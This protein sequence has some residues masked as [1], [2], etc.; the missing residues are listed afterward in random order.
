MTVSAA[1]ACLPSGH[2]VSSLLLF[3]F[4]LFLSS[5][6]S[7]FIASIASSLHIAPA[8]LGSHL[9]RSTHEH[10][11]TTLDSTRSLALVS[12]MTTYNAQGLPMTD[13]DALGVY[14]SPVKQSTAS[15]PTTPSI[16]REFYH[17]G[18]QGSPTSPCHSISSSSMATS[19]SSGSLSSVASHVS[20]IS[21]S[22]AGLPN[23]FP[24]NVIKSASPG[25][26][27][28]PFTARRPTTPS[29]GPPPPTPESVSEL[30]KTINKRA[31]S[32]SSDTSSSSPA[33]KLSPEKK[34]SSPKDGF[35]VWPEDVEAAFMEG[36]HGVCTRYS[37]GVS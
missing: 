31:R 21:G 37:R 26:P 9:S 12:T 14:S 13:Q 16:K 15:R 25:R 20:S 29:S 18:L 7:T 36:G 11:S 22:E 3:V 27:T 35:E 10:L 8:Q 5:F 17:G 1:A 33:K 30:H 19:G 28:S 2:P 6:T 4:H 23:C 34:S 32:D 24:Y